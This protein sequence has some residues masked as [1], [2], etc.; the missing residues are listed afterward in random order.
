MLQ[1][2]MLIRVIVGYKIDFFHRPPPIVA[3][4]VQYNIQNAQVDNILAST[5]SVR[6]WIDRL[7]K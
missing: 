4:S 6:V 7:N 1:C 5:L 2:R 3:S